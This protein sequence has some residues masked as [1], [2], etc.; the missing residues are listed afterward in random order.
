M[1]QQAS[2]TT[3]RARSPSTTRG[4]TDLPNPRQADRSLSSARISES[5]PRTGRTARADRPDT[6]A[7]RT[8][9]R[10][11]TYDEVNLKNSA[12]LIS[13]ATSAIDTLDNTF[14]NIKSTSKAP[15]I[16]EILSLT[17]RVNNIIDKSRYIVSVAIESNNAVDAAVASREACDAACR[18]RDSADIAAKLSYLFTTNVVSEIR[19]N[20]H[21]NTGKLSKAFRGAK[22]T[23]A[24]G[25]AFHAACADIDAA[26]TE[27]HNAWRKTLDNYYKEVDNVFTTLKVISYVARRAE[28]AKDFHLPILIRDVGNAL[29][30][31]RKII[32]LAERTTKNI[33]FHTE[34]CVGEL[35]PSINRVTKYVRDADIAFR[36]GSNMFKI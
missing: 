22:V 27:A 26:D 36:E 6:S 13:E 15:N 20:P 21:A 23:T 33:R 2:S 17:S 8:I 31:L 29:S 11:V 28:E 7:V 4:R 32:F 24:N 10:T 5:L 34:R 14:A 16:E 25:A 3:L 9:S 1:R 35:T 30:R 12:D 18:A 19:S